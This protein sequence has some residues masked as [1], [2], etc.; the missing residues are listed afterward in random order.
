ML[1]MAS[2]SSTLLFLSMQ[3]HATLETT[4]T[5]LAS[6]NACNFTLGLDF[7][8]FVLQYLIVNYLFH[9][10]CWIFTIPALIEGR[11]MGPQYSYNFSA[12]APRLS[13]LGPNALFPFLY[14][15]TL[16]ISILCASSV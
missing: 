1:L 4:W 15:L 9:Y 8:L 3:T 6:Q 10:F 2:E 16:P 11:K 5:F 12:F 7:T 14:S 13:E